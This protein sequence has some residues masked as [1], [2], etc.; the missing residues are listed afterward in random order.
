MPA[1]AGACS[2]PGSRAQG[3]QGCPGT[4]AKGQ[5]TVD[6]H[7]Q[8]LLLWHFFP[9]AQPPTLSQCLSVPPVHCRERGRFVRWGLQPGRAHPV[10]QHPLGLEEQQGGVCSQPRRDLSP[11]ANSL[12]RDGSSA[13][14]RLR[15]SPS[16]FSSGFLWKTRNLL[17]VSHHPPLCVRE[18]AAAM[19][20]VSSTNKWPETRYA[21]AS[22]DKRISKERFY[23][24][25]EPQ[26][27]VVWS[28]HKSCPE[29]P[30]SLSLLAAGELGDALGH[31][32]PCASASAR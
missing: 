16:R 30:V 15:P 22:G 8:E 11:L 7:K 32:L 13:A 18:R 31:P 5:K 17:L 26:S 10:T 29:F 2:C 4:R 12:P 19:A 3:S 24:P 9:R 6:T 27:L 23:F 14:S 25:S 1:D 20:P 28:K 21:G